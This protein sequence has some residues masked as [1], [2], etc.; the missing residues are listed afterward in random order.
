MHGVGSNDLSPC[1]GCGLKPIPGPAPYVDAD[2][3]LGILED[4]TQAC[5]GHRGVTTPYVVIS[6]G[7]VPGTFRSQAVGPWIALYGDDA[8]AF[9]DAQGVGPNLD[10]AKEAAA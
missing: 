5:C 2:P 4:V 3:C 7:D 6:P 9:F 1:Q 10:L 8:L